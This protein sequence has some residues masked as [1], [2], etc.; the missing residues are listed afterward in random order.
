M[1]R[2]FFA[3]LL[4]AALLL[5]FSSCK[6][7]RAVMRYETYTVSAA[8]YTYWLSRFKANFLTYY[9]D[10]E[11]SD[12]YYDSVIGENGE[13]AEEVMTSLSDGRIMEYLIA[14][15][16]FDQSG[17]TVPEATAESLDAL[18]DSV[19]AGAA[20]G[21][22]KAFDELAASFG[23]GYDD[24]REIYRIEAKSE[25]FRS[26]YKTNFLS[27]TDADRD[28]YFEENYA[29]TVHI[30]ISTEYRLNIDENGTLIYDENGDYTVPYTAAEKTAQRQKA[31]ELY[32][33]LTAENFDA[34]REEY[35]E[36]PAVSAYP[37]GYYLS[38]NTEGFDSDVIAAALSMQEGEVRRVEASHGVFFLK[39]LP[40]EEKAYEDPANAD[41][42]DNFEDA[43]KNDLYER[44][45]EGE[46][47]KVTV[48][49]ALK[50]E[51]AIRSVTPCYDF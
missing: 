15:Y 38:A 1:K 4:A 50:K 20:A 17:L 43:L 8:Y 45:L 29:R 32:G 19:V 40:K 49:A 27:V 51:I 5:S 35:N 12:A 25:R 7:E 42:F 37:N 44:F 39:K 31:A 10:V 41:F 26:Y 30:Y 48:D 28:A 46:K 2:R 22:R 13:T 21:D 47:A 34:L 23:I 16:L 36:D 11:D 9:S 3:A 24:L 14:E 6:R 18:L 33:K